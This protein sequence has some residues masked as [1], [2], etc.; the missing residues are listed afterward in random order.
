MDFPALFF[1]FGVDST[2][3]VDWILHVSAV[4]C[5]F[6]FGLGECNSATSPH[7]DLLLGLMTKTAALGTIASSSVYWWNLYAEI[8][9]LYPTA[10]SLHATIS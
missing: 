3:H 10:V 1:S 6:L 9:A 8:P 2:V 5:G 7:I 4:S